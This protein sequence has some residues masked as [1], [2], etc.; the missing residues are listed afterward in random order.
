MIHVNDEHYRS[1]FLGNFYEVNT[2]NC[3]GLRV[4]AH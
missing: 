4:L 3:T 1:C 2:G